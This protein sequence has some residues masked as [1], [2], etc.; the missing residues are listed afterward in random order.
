MLQGRMRHRD[1][2]GNSGLIQSAG[3][4]WMTAGRGIIHSEMPEQEQGL[5]SGFQL[6]LNL[7]AK[8]KLCPQYYQDLQPAQLAEARLGSAGSRLRL[9]AGLHD[10]LVGPVR[11]RATQPLLL[12]AALEDERALELH[13]PA[14]HAAFVFVNQG[15]VSI[16]PEGQAHELAAGTCAR[17]D[18]GTR[19]R[20]R[21][22]RERAE[23]LVAAARPLREPV[24]QRGPFVMN[25]E[26]EIHQA[27]AD[28]RAGVLDKA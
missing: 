2:R 17:L 9:I 21:A 27:I 20:L 5:M 22:T 3:A 24:V 16:G 28:Y 19:L 26:A 7:P 10:G 23:V 4:Q 1:S 18:D 15:S 25:T 14:G 8:E 6:W 11:E 12:T 13:T